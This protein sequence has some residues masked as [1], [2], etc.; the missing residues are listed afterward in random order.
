MLV[1]QSIALGVLIGD[2]AKLVRPRELRGLGF[3]AHPGGGPK[4]LSGLLARDIAHVF[5]AGHAVLR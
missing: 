5:H 3:L 4:V 2:A 1:A